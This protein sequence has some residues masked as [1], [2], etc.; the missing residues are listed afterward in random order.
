M[1]IDIA[2]VRTQ[3]GKLYLIVAIDRIFKFAYIEAHPQ[4]SKALAAQFFRYFFLYRQRKK[5]YSGYS[6]SALL[7]NLNDKV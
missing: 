4:T 6:Y 5:N 1:Y 7:R 3:E 2:E